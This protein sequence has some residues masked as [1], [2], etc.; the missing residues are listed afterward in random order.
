MGPGGRGGQGTIF[1]RVVLEP[2]RVEVEGR[3]EVQDVRTAT[4]QQVR[5]DQLGPD[6]H[7]RLSADVN[8]VMSQFRE[9]GA[10]DTQV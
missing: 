10:A 7:K 6:G 9:H 4:L 5:D 8:T 1:T 3:G 2:D